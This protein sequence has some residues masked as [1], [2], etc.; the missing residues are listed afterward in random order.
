MI[1]HFLLILIWGMNTLM[2]HHFLNLSSKLS[3]FIFVAGIM[4]WARFRN[5][6]F[7]SIVP[8]LMLMFML[9][10]LAT[11]QASNDLDWLDEVSVLPRIHITKN[12]V[13]IEN[14][15]NFTWKG[16]NNSDLNWETRNFDL[17]KLNELYLVVVPFG[18]SEYMAHTMLIFGFEEQ[19]NII[20]SVETRKEKNENYSLI[21]GALRQLELIYVFGSE[22]D[23]LTLR[24][25]H[26]NAK[27]YIYPIK[28]EPEFMIS[29][30][31][32][33][34]RSAN[35]LH[36]NPTFYRTLR[37]NCT[38]TLVKHIDRHYQQKIGV[39]LET[40]F[41]AQAGK[42]LH[43]FGRMDTR[44]SYEQAHAVSRV[45]D[46]VEQHASAKNF[47]VLL[48]KQLAQRFIEQ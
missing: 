37:D 12:D 48:H 38:S 18:D 34:A 9:V 21:A 19:E 20:V 14:F 40:V 22:Q 13:K 8:P 1:K 26:R 44:L 43:E 16:I 23:L 11:I 5:R 3:I 15:R 32:D 24:A 46:L 36:E 25:I 27:L 31:K 39:R 45:D 29:L 33:L 41:P 17:T 30:F 4:L 2:L 7:I 28:A 42:L 35:A 10:W 47:S 6:Q